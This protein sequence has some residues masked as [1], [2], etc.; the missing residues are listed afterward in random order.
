MMNEISG[1]VKEQLEQFNATL[2]QVIN[3]SRGLYLKVK[4]EGN[5]QIKGLIEV[6]QTQDGDAFLSQLKKDVATPFEDVKGSI[7]QIKNASFG[8]L[9]KARESSDKVFTELVELGQKKEEKAPVSA[10]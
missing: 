7:E 6:G 3:A 10:E 5:K 9:V 8:L 2:E 1:L 4:E